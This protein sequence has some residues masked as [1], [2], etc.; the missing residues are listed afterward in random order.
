MID[1][2]PFFGA[3]A[4]GKTVLAKA[5]DPRQPSG[6][7]SADILRRMSAEEITYARLLVSLA[8]CYPSLRLCTESALEVLAEDAAAAAAIH[9]TEHTA[10]AAADTRLSSAAVVWKEELTD[11]QAIAVLDKHIEAR[12]LSLIHI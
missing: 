4:L 10:E 11:V 8:K 9:A 7:T 6:Q 1:Q 5:L 3:D 2:A 12:H